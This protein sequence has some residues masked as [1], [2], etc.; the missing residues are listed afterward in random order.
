M[1][2]A[3]IIEQAAFDSPSPLRIDAGGSSMSFAMLIPAL[4]TTHESRTLK[5]PRVRLR[6]IDHKV[7]SSVV[8][9]IVNE[10]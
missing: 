10:R 1:L 8:N 2:A 4:R 9:T 6:P 3:G 5:A 7:R